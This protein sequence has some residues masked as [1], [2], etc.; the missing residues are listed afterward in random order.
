MRSVGR[1]ELCERNSP[2]SAAE[3]AGNRGDCLPSGADDVF[4]SFAAARADGGADGGADA[5]VRVDDAPGYA[6]IGEIIRRAGVWSLCD[7]DAFA[8]EAENIR[9]ERSGDSHHRSRPPPL[10]AKLALAFGTAG[11]ED[12]WTHADVG[13]ADPV[14]DRDAKANATSLRLEAKGLDSFPRLGLAPGLRELVV[15]RNLSLIHI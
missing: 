11:V 13:L 4:R 3:C 2:H 1:C 9:S 7:G 12:A 14:N 15:A 8:R 6:A 10:G 5:L